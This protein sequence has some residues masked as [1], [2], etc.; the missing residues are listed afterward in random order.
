ME[1]QFNPWLKIRFHQKIRPMNNKADAGEFPIDSTFDVELA[2]KLARLETYNKHYYRPN[3]YLHK[4]WA[5]RCGTTFR[6]ILKHLVTDPD[7]QDYY[8]PGGLEGK[9]IL[10]PMMGGG[11]TLHEALRMGANVIGM[12]LDPIP[13][14]QARATLTRT[15]LSELEPTFTQFS[16]T[17][18]SD[19]SGYY[20]TSCPHCHTAAESWFVL[21]G[22]RRHCACR[23]VLVVDSLLLRQETNGTDVRL[24]PN[25]REVKIGR[26]A[27]NC[28]EHNDIP[29]VERGATACPYCHEKYQENRSL[30]YYAR[31]EALVVTGHCPEHKLF[32]RSID[33]TTRTALQLA[34]DQRSML[35][36]PAQDFTVEPG[37]KS[38]HLRQRGIHSYLDL[39]SSRQLLVLARA[40]ELLPQSNLPRLNLALLFSTSLE[41]NSLLCGYKGKSKRR[42]GAIRHVFAHHAYSFPYTALENNPLY[43][44]KSSGTLQKLFHARI[45]RARL[46]AIQPRE[47]DLTRPQA[48]F[49]DIVGEVDQG[50]E[51]TELTQLRESSH[52][53]LLHQG[54]ATRINLPDDSVDAIVTDPPYFDSIQYSDLSAY[55]RVWLRH[56]LPDCADW[57]FDLSDSAVD[58]HN[59]DRASRYTELISRIFAECA[60]VLRKPNGRLIFT[61]H[62]WN[63]RAWTALTTSL[64]QANFTL[65]N[66]AVVHSENPISVH[67][68]NMNALT[69]DAILVLAPRKTARTRRW[70]PPQKIDT[71]SSEAFSRDCV[72]LLGWIL[73]SDLSIEEIG[74]LW[75]QVMN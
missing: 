23:E 49:V 5:R 39:F 47:R 68:A 44:R 10:D 26:A 22:A 63:P 29:V 9:I 65:L 62:H 33:Q 57:T 54:S 27:C 61:F 43:P 34:D 55:F 73:D 7:Q 16:N 19:L 35:P 32:F 24:C 69:H 3:T 14:L 37:R 66:H 21:Y 15:S 6:L 52:R 72:T 8:S 46:W 71:S 58:P 67:I 13:V 41:F 38:I 64:R 12:D 75:Q 45:R 11:T 48:A 4:W 36:F 70:A 51:M 28:P 56:M 50:I 59:N 17:I 25:C 30:P 60:R 1:L 2:N 40:T 20:E 18:R 42:P 53:F 74:L 31:Y